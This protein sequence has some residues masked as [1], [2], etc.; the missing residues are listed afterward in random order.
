MIVGS[1]AQSIVGGWHLGNAGEANSA[2][3]ITFLNNGSYFMAED[4]DSIADPSGQD[5]MERGSYTWNPST[6]AFSST[7]VVD[8]SGEWGLSHSGITTVS[9][10]GNSLNFN[11]DGESFTLTRVALT[12]LG[13]A[14]EVATVA[15]KLPGQSIN[16]TTFLSTTR[17]DWNGETGN[18]IY[19]KVS[20]N[21]GTLTQTYDDDGNNPNVYREE[22]LMTFTTA[23][24]GTYIYREYDGGALDFQTTGNFD[25]PWLVDTFII[26]ASSA[27]NGILSPGGNV[28]VSAGGNQIFSATPDSGYQVDQWTL[29]GVTVQTGGASYS[30]T[31]VQSSGQLVVSFKI[32]PLADDDVKSPGDPASP[33]ASTPSSFVTTKTSKYSGFLVSTDGSQTLGYFKSIKVSK[34]GTF[35]AK[36]YFGNILYSM[37]GQ[38]DQNGQYSDVITPRNGSPATVSLQLVSTLSGGHK[39]EGDV[40]V[41]GEQAA[42]VSAVKSG[43]TGS[44]A[45]VYTILVLSDEEESSAPQGHGY[46][47][48]T[49]TSV[50]TVKL[51]GLLGD[52]TKWSAKCS[53]TPDGEMPLYAVLYKETGSLGGLI[54][55]RNVA[56]ISDCDGEVHWRKPG[57]F[58]LQRNLIGSRYSYTGARVIAAITNTAPNVEAHVGA[59]SG[60]DSGS[61]DLEW[62]TSN[63][64][65]YVGPEKV[66]L[67][68]KN[69]Q[70][71]G[72]A[73][74]DGTKWKVEGVVFQKQDLAAGMVYL[75]KGQP[76]SLVIVPVGDNDDDTDQASESIV[77]TWRSDD[78]SYLLFFADGTYAQAQKVE[79]AGV[80]LEQGTYQF[81]ESTGLLTVT[82]ITF[83][84]NGE[85]GLSSDPGVNSSD[86]DGMWNVTG[87]TLTI[88]SD[89]DDNGTAESTFTL[90]KVVQSS[91]LQGTWLN[92]ENGF[93]A[94][95]FNNDGTYI[96]LENSSEPEKGIE[97]GTYSFTNNRLIPTVTL[98]LN[99]SIG[100]TD[101]QG[102][103]F[104]VN[105]GASTFTNGIDFNLIQFTRP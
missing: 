43:S 49:V 52:G 54:R 90:T 17:F 35:S 61:F 12:L 64:I 8:T 85:S 42:Y 51:K 76:R 88:T 98:D 39:L 2:V 28:N 75:K 91:D 60:E 101:S 44:L 57:G 92:R 45:G 81:D 6:G 69:G 21:A 100:L 29:G 63:K 14:P 95:V 30:M 58:D 55:F 96:H 3:V 73:T 50:G 16:Q 11:S 84:Q 13:L 79:S 33:P 68:T 82:S 103:G 26:N 32:R 4:G 9:V 18:W 102:I 62:T 5:G 59:G 67:K 31:N 93:L 72:S 36:M 46:A 105:T 37:K 22:T 99:G 15:A 70:I 66:K 56:G 20:A 74:E 1:N 86:G 24:S 80:G 7:T 25:F 77:G 53:V 48:M 71:K 34:K 38:F 41:V 87:N 94:L 97:F 40:T 47:M 65:L 23:T 27:G 83:D 10:T 78:G 19:T 89:E 104:D